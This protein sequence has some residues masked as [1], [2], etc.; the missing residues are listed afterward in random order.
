[1]EATMEN[2]IITVCDS[3]LRDGSYGI[4][5]TFSKKNIAEITAG[6]AAAGVKLIE[7]GHG[8]GI[9]GSS[10]TFGRAVLS[11][12]EMLETAVANKGDSEIIIVCIP[13]IGTMEDIKKAYNLGVKWVRVAVHA[14]ESDITEQHITQCKALGMNVA[15]M[16][17]T[18]HVLNLEETLM[19]AK[20]LESYGAD[21]V[22]LAD[23]CGTMFPEDVKERFR[24]RFSVRV[25][26]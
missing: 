10:L 18:S 21:V 3:T 4:S 26:P 8:D 7:V 14:T 5:H 25:W 1:M 22:Y 12:E 9:G 24:N 15:A 2:K 6:L 13:G 23:S 16:L 20:R 17:S 11:D 19:H